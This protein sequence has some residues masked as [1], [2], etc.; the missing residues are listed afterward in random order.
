MLT[1]LGHDEAELV[2]NACTPRGHYFFAVRQF[3]SLYAFVLDV[4]QAVYEEHDF[5]WDVGGA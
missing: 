3:G 4:D 5:T 1:E 2:M